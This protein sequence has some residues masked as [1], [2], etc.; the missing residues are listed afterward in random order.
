[1]TQQEIKKLAYDGAALPESLSAPDALYFLMARAIYADFK[2]KRLSREDAAAEDQRALDAAQD[3]RDAL[4][5]AK[6]EREERARK[7]RAMDDQEL[8]RLKDGLLEDSKRH[9]TIIMATERYRAA[10]RKAKDA[11]AKLRAADAMVAALDNIPINSG[12][13]ADE[14][15]D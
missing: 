8:R 13:E 14:K 15:R 6:A 2:A 4:E 12:G 7:R 5:A 10:Y 1:M 11:E 3:Y 9:Q